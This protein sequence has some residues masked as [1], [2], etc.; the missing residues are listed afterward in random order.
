M[1]GD[2]ET[3]SGAAQDADIPF[4]LIEGGYTVKKVNQIYHNHVVKNFLG[5]EK[6]VEKYLN[7]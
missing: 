5:L 7:D 4:V 1:V 3:D 6:I 2:S